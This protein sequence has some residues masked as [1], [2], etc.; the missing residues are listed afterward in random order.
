MSQ[1]QS[2]TAAKRNA[3]A[4]KSDVAWPPSD[5]MPEVGETPRSDRTFHN[6]EDSDQEFGATHACNPRERVI[7]KGVE[8]YL[9]GQVR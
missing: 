1:R 3:F 6:A 7:T 5:L 4:A 2:S 9:Q 8:N